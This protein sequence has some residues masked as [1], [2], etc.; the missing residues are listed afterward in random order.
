MNYQSW[1]GVQDS[2][3]GYGSMLAGF[4][5]SA[6][7]VVRFDP[8]ASSMV[9]MGVPYGL[10]RWYKGQ[11]LSC[12]TMW[13][14]DTLPAQ[15]VRWLGLY[16]QILVPCQHNVELFSPHHPNVQYVPLGVDRKFW[17]P[18][19]DP[20]GVF[21]FHAGGSLWTRKG[22][23]IVVKAFAKLRL[24]DAELHIKAAPHAKDV[25]TT[26]MPANVFLHRN[27]MSLEEQRDWYG[28]A[29]VFVAPAR[30]EGFGLMPLQAISMGIPTIVSHSSGQIEFEHLATGVAPTRKSQ[31]NIGFWD[32]THESHLA[33]LMMDHYRNWADKRAEALVKAKQAD[34]FDWRK[35]TAK[36]LAALPVGTLLSDPPVETPDIKVPIQVKRNQTCDIG[37]QHFVFKAGETYYVD[38]GVHQVLFDAGVLA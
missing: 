9:Y 24:P 19:A 35:S 36:L 8:L 32:E 37:R 18:Q 27:W 26:R 11:V 2:K 21:R 3:F 29:N 20:D 14:T 33:E 1:L 6:P 5:D 17:V 30:G 31:A 16:D 13:E 38:E 34:V 23:D 15:F 28:K 25:P 22:L 12:F 7:K 10:E 4:V